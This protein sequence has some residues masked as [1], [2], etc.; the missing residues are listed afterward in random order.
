MASN[1]QVGEQVKWQGAWLLCLKVSR[2]SEGMRIVFNNAGWYDLIPPHKVVAI[3][4][5]TTRDD[6]QIYRGSEG[7]R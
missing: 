7:I 3:K 6:W 1:L 2:T 5:G 4:P